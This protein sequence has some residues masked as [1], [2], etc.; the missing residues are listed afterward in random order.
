MIFVRTTATD[1]RARELSPNSL[2][3]AVSF[4]CCPAR[5]HHECILGSSTT[6]CNKCGSLR[7]VAHGSA[8]QEAGQGSPQGSAAA[9]SPASGRDATNLAHPRHAPGAGR[10][11]G[12]SKMSPGPTSEEERV[13]AGG[14]SWEE[15][16]ARA[17]AAFESGMKAYMREDAEVGG[18]SRG[19]VFVILPRSETP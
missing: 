14:E 3:R 17:G 13:L 10:G 5:V 8:T 19:V 11:R 18:R 4:L 16:L 7:A 6:C 1:W 9:A 15:S 2:R 12:G